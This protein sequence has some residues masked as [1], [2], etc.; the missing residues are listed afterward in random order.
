MRH[1]NNYVIFCALCT[2]FFSIELWAQLDPTS[3]MLV[4]PPVKDEARPSLD[5]GRY[6][7]RQSNTSRESKSGEVTKTLSDNIKKKNIDAPE[8][9]K[10]T[11]PQTE[12]ATKKL[13]TSDIEAVDLDHA[14]DKRQNLVII[15]V[16]PNYLYVNSSSHY[17]F[18]NYH[19]AGP[20]IS[21]GADVWLSP[22]VGI[23]IGY[24]TSLVADVKAEPTASRAI[25][26][27]HRYSTVGLQFRKYTSTSRRS[28]NFVWGVKFSD[29]EM[30]LPA[31]E[32]YRTRLHTTGLGLS[33]KA[34]LPSTISEAWTA[35]SE[36]L[37][38]LKV[39]EEKTAASLK[40]GADVTSYGVKL[41]LGRE[42]ILD[43][44]NQVFWRI[45]HRVDKSVYEGTANQNDP[46]TGI[47]PKGVSVTTGSTLLEFGY[48][49]GE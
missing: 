23:N 47:A 14:E 15:S 10:A 29:Y 33:I 2:L 6:I 35:E 39:Q 30:S 3:T 36:L 43:R 19:S 9:V 45:S 8:N 4:R 18:R 25:L 12:D 48:A 46:I 41:S 49:W 24:L 34:T 38:K 44:R 5:S 1:A 20:G 13:S 16:A 21:I 26:T 31:E 28:L 37:P 17:W 7:I 11:P 40:S 42:Y 27:D 22:T 32:K